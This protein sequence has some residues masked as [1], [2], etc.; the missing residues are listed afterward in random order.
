MEL[1]PSSEPPVAHLLK[2]FPTLYGTRRFITVFTRALNWC[3]SWARSIQSIPPRHICL[4]SILI[5]FS[6][7]LGGLPSGLFPSGFPPESYMHSS[8]PPCVLHALP[9]HP[10]WLDHSNY[11]W[12]TVQV[13]KL[14]IVH[15]PPTSYHFIPLRFKCSPQHPVL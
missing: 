10:P 3:L 14:L 1:S 2:D 8:S 5:L 13:M 9:S 15:F 7:I 11:T 6:Y 4:R 12:R